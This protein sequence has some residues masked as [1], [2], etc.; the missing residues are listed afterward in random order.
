MRKA[1]N[2]ANRFITCHELQSKALSY[3]QKCED[4]ATVVVDGDV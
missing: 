4:C 3:D 1:I 2:Y